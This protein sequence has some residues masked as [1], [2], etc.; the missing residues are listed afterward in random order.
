M[1]H[2]AI[3]D[4]ALSLIKRN[5]LESSSYTSDGGWQLSDT[6]LEPRQIKTSRALDKW[7]LNVVAFKGEGMEAAE[8]LRAKQKEQK[9]V[10][11][12]DGT[13]KSWGQWTINTIKTE[14]TKIIERG[15][16]QVLKI[17]ISL[18][19]YRQDENQSTI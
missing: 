8:G 17:T 6:I 9:P 3:D 11:V 18:T 5:P 15:V 2:L 16:A 14:Y 13:G 12:T 19:E 4:Y 7:D 1:Q 10:M